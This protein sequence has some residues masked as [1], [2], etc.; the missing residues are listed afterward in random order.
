[1]SWNI[2]ANARSSVPTTFR[3]FRLGFILS[4]WLFAG[5]PTP[6]FGI[7]FQLNLIT[8]ETLA[9]NGMISF[10]LVSPNQGQANQPISVT[11]KKGTSANDKAAAIAAQFA[12]N[13]IP[14]WI[15]VNVAN[16]NTIFFEAA[17]EELNFSKVKRITNFSDT[18]MEMSTLRAAGDPE[19]AFDFGIGGNI[20][21]GHDDDLNPSFAFF[22]T[23][24]VMGQ[25]ATA[26]AN[27]SPDEG[28]NQVITDLER[29]LETQDVPF[30]PTS[31]T[32]Y[33]LDEFGDAPFISFQVTDS[34]LFVQGAGANI[35]PEIPEPTSLTLF[36]TGLGAFSTILIIRRR[37]LLRTDRKEGV[38][39]RSTV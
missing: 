16:T 4:L 1:M 20:A 5:L 14:H 36:T 26:R 30:T 35:L 29:Q 2:A 24:N 39:I 17:N 19:V 38:V 18:T 12:G 9:D 23:L 8:G 32:S 33:S 21:S 3:V 10:V 22:Q 6:A 7:E 37:R 13:A 15:A 27:I 31:P 34:N 25:I 11:F 28:A